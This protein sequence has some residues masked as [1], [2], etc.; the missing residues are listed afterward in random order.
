M[1]AIQS[2]KKQLKSIK[3]TQKLTKAMQTVATVKFSKLSAIS[4]Q[5]IPYGKACSEMFVH[6]SAEMLSA[7]RPALAEAPPAVVVMAA[8]KG[9]CGGFNTELL[10]FAAGRLAEMDDYLL[11]A[12]GKKAIDFFK[13]KNLPLAAEYIFDDVPLQSE[14]SA[15]LNE[16]INWRQQGK[17]SRIY[18]IYPHYVNMMN[19]KPEIYELFE[20]PAEYIYEQELFIPDKITLG[21]KAS[22]IIFSAI[23]YR[24]VLE[25][26]LGAQAAMLMTMRSAYDTASEYC[27][28]LEGQINRKR[29]NAVTSDVLETAGERG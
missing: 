27:L 18:V 10:E 11:I 5:Y 22:N 15:L 29:Q 19:Q 3:S 6:H 13:A 12:C 16:L 7:M 4:S 1:P 8:N 25:T 2:L 17:V 20:E 21:E 28:R 9:F 23:F 24:L 14:S 26:A